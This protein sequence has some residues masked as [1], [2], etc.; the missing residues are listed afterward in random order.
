MR[1]FITQGEYLRLLETLRLEH[2][3]L[4]HKRGKMKRRPRRKYFHDVT[5]QAVKGRK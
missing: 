1:K 4:F 2:P 3:H 5:V